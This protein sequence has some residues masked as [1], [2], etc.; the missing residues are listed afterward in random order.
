LLK[1]QPLVSVVIGSF[2]A[3]PYLRASLLSI[4]NQSYTRLQIILIDDG[5]TD[6]SVD[7]ISDLNDPR[8]M[9]IRQKNQGRSA[10]LN[11]AIDLVQGD[12]YIIQDA[13]DVSQPQRVER[14][15][16]AME[17]SERL[18]AVFSGWDLILNDRRI[19]PRFRAISAAECMSLIN[20]LS[21]PAHDPTGMF[22]MSLVGHYRYST[23]LPYTEAVDY[24]L[25]IGEKHPIEVVGECLYSYRIH[26]NSITA[27]DPVRRDAFV[28]ECYRRACERRGLVC[29]RVRPVA[30]GKRRLSNRDRDN[31][32]AAHYMES[33]VD[34]RAAGFYFRAV[35]TGI[36]CAMLHPAD[37]HYYK[38]LAFAVVPVSVRRLLRP[39]ERGRSTRIASQLPESPA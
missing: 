5:S 32:L 29:D 31:N 38:A 3:G 23:D 8:L 24:I 26:A 39:S 16:R 21:I 37:P 18:A 10:T 1:G 28:H 2:N 22:R 33:V 7:G 13:D 35:W 30:I 4:L 19:A 11:R 17:E 20:Q 25:R 9:I 27:R 6:D 15:V 14:L 36:E 12:Y 34:L